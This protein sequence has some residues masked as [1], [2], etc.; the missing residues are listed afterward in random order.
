MN[1]HYPKIQFRYELN[2][3]NEKLF[4][5]VLVKRTSNNKFETSVFRKSTN[6]NIFV[7]WNTSSP[8]DWKTETLKTLTKPTKTIYWN[9]ILLK[10]E[11][12]HLRQV[13]AGIRS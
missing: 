5:D 7:N 9:K 1:S 4:L 6:T 13:F 3:S 8:T 2:K 10:T 11:I 12:K